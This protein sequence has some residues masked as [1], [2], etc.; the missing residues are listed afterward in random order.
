M[1]NIHTSISTLSIFAYNQ[2]SETH[3]L[4]YLVIDRKSPHDK[5]KLEAVWADI[6]RQYMDATS[7]RQGAQDVIDL[8]RA[9]LDLTIE[10]NNVNTLIFCCRKCFEPDI[11]EELNA[12]GFNVK[13]KKDL[14]KIEKSNKRLLTEIREKQF[15]LSN[16][17]LKRGTPVTFEKLL[18]RINVHFKLTINPRE[19]TVKEWIAIEDNFTEDLRRNK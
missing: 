3:D 15:A 9:I 17:L 13:S 8:Q 12:Y 6:V 11:I 5:T 18:H 1:T 4:N 7:H 14:D 19:T 16:K 2:I 10:Y